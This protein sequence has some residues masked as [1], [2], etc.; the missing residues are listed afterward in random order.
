[1]EGL[2]L[3][4]GIGMLYFMA[5]ARSGLLCLEGNFM[6]MRLSGNWYVVTVFFMLICFV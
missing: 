6:Y 4:S 1:M 5:V 2:G 3:R